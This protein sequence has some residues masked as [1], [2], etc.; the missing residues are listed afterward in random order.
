M[1]A[2]GGPH[3]GGGK[4]DVRRSAGAKFRHVVVAGVA[5]VLVGAGLVP[6]TATPAEAAP[7]DAPVVNPVAC[8]NTKAGSPKSEWDVSGAGSTTIQGF[9][10]DISVNVGG[11][12][13]L[14]DRHT[15]PVVPARHLSD[16][17]LRGERRPEDRDRQRHR[18]PSRRTSRPAWSHPRP[19]WSTAATGRCRPPGPCRPTAVSGIYFAKLVRDRRHDRLQPHRLRRP[20]RRQHTRTSLFQTSDTTW[21]A[22]NQYG[23]NSLYVG[24]PGRARLQGQLQPAV[25]HPG[26]RHRRTSSSTPSTRWSASS[27]P[28]AT[29]SATPPASTPI[30]AA[31]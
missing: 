21:Q 6:I 8:E 16:G 18:R 27:R 11:T 3:R 15:G 12:V 23:G 28:T 1:V 30:A 19:G 17:L 9:A 7:C 20:Q 31:R 22:Y 25:H 2:C 10:T 5:G 29:T 24:Q 14:Q 26:H 4:V 13:Q